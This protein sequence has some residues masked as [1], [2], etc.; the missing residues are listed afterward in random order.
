MLIR[1]RHFGE[2]ELA[3]D[4]I[5]DFESGILGFED[6]KR[7]TILY[8]S[9]REENPAVSWLQSLDEPALAIPVI[10]PLLILED[11]NPQIDDEFLKPLGEITEDNTVVLISVTV[12][13]DITKISANLR[14]P[15]IIN[16]DEKKGSQVIVENSDYAIKYYFYEK[17]QEQKSVK[18]G[19]AYVSPIS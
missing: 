10:S 2:I 19:E 17:L 16:S 4:K 5:I 14:A 7:Y 3:E 9:E 1:T 11:Y 18:E 13:S 12:P 15:F 8:D 6:Y